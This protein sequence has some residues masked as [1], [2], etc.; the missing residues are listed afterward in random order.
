MCVFDYPPKKAIGLY[1]FNLLGNLFQATSTDQRIA[2]SFEPP[3]ITKQERDHQFAS[4][5][6]F[7]GFLGP[8]KS[9]VE[10]R[11]SLAEPRKSLVE[12][13]CYHAVTTPSH[14]FLLEA[15]QILT[16][17]LCWSTWRSK[18]PIL[19]GIFFSQ[20]YMITLKLFTTSAPMR[21]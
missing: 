9:L 20:S 5:I 15:K 1:C 19:L 14:F 12:P 17:T 10:P 13:R 18:S 6:G 3:G 4:N 2:C 11:K 21:T 8:R 16:E 7:W